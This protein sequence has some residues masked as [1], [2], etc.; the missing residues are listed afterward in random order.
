MACDLVIRSTRCSVVGSYINTYR[1]IQLFTSGKNQGT[2]GTDAYQTK[3]IDAILKNSNFAV[4]VPDQDW[5]K[6]EPFK[7][8]LF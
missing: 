3:T 1:T 5:K 7:A 2:D 8:F 6:L 4:A